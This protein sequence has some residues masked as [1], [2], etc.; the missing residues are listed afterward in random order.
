LLTRDYTDDIY[1]STNT[2]KEWFVESVGSEMFANVLVVMPKLKAATFQSEQQQMMKDYF[3]ATDA[4]EDKRLPEMAKLR[5][6]EIKDKGRD[7]WVKFLTAACLADCP[8][9]ELDEKAKEFVLKG[10][11]A[12]VKDKRKK[13]LYNVIAPDAFRSLGME[14]KDQNVVYRLVVV[15]SAA[16]DV[17]KACRR[18]GFTARIF[19]Y[20]KE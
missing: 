1:A 14:D 18:K 17:I 6:A 13:R 19:S 9:E 20:D 4:Q 2:V 12:E 10:M 11:Q 5:L 7:E 16:E 15:K 3:D 8:E